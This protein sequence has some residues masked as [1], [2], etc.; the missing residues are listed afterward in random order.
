[1][2]VVVHW[3]RARLPRQRPFDGI[4]PIG[5]RGTFA[6]QRHRSGRSSAHQ[7]RT[8]TAGVG[9]AQRWRLPGFSPVLSDT[10]DTLALGDERRQQRQRTNEPVT[11][12]RQFGWRCLC[13]PDRH[14]L[15]QQAYIKSD[16]PPAATGMISSGIR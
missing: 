15:T 14:R 12:L 1:M 6:A 9:D 10:S 4:H 16:A 5:R 13:S 11:D 7:A 8:P 3:S 2:A